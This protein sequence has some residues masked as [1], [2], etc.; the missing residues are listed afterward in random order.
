Y[1]DCPRNLEVLGG[2]RPLLYLS[3]ND[4]NIITDVNVRIEAAELLALMLSNNT[5]VQQ[6]C[7]TR[8]HGL[9]RLQNR[10]IKLSTSSPHDD[11][12][13]AAL[14]SA[15]G[16][17]I[18]NYPQ[19]ESAF[20]SDSNGTQLIA[21]LLN[22]DY[23]IRVQQ[24]AG[25][26]YRY[27]LS[28][29]RATIVGSDDVAKALI[30]LYHSAGGD[31]DDGGDIQYYEILAGLSYELRAFPGMADAVKERMKRILSSSNKK[32]YQPELSILIQTAKYT[33]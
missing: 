7:Y 33:T 15:L 31:N 1:P 2:T 13:L 4:N 20:I 17:L 22:K 14:L 24:K 5:D 26:L 23:S 11:K 12:E 18:R 10:L 25:S 9:H 16:S 29:G 19:A 21:T 30:Q 3:C 6:A 32:D 27:L 8:Y 28:D